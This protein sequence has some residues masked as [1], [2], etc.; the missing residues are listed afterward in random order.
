M[1]EPVRDVGASVGARLLNLAKQQNRIFDRLVTRYVLER[2]L[3]R[4]SITAHRDRLVLKGAMLIAAWFADPHR[5]TRDVDFL[6]LGSSDPATMLDV[7]RDICA[8][9]IDDGVKFDATK[10]S[11]D[12]IREEQRYGGLRL[13]TEATVGGA[14]V[15]VVID[16]GFGDTVEPEMEE[17]ELPIM[18]DLPA[19]RLW[20]YTR[21]SVI[22]EKFHAMVILGRAN[23]RMRDYYD[24]WLLARTHEFAGERLAKAIAATFRRRQTV[25]PLELPDG[26]ARAFAEDPTKRRQWAAFANEVSENTV[27]L[28]EVIDDLAAFLWP[29]AVEARMIRADERRREP[30][31][32]G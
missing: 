22:A 5:E 20:A 12:R 16:V 3:Y 4:L 32:I 31:A 19:P 24:I 2:L 7:F 14:R 27:P 8:V 15:R 18:L 26:L 9:E 6:G 10:L 30:G 1:P 23:S 28:A 11:V 25:I 17:I 13:K 29:R 21:E